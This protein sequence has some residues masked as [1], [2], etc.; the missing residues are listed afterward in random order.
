MPIYYVTN[1]KPLSHNKKGSRE[2][3][4]QPFRDEFNLKYS[5]LYKNLPIEND[6]LKSRIIYIHQL[7]PGNTPDVDNLSKPIVD[8]FSGVMYEDDRQIIE[9][10]AVILERK[11]FDFVIVDATNMPLEIYEDFNTYY[12]EKAEHIILF[13]IDTVLPSAIKIGEIWLWKLE[14]MKF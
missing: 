8:A 6:K 11:E 3:Y 4:K 9:R 14:W 12:E 7:K 5:R 1:K 13:G 2:E 10:S